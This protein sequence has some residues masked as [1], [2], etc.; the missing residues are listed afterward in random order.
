MQK[1]VVKILEK[2]HSNKLMSEAAEK[3]TLTQENEELDGEG[4]ERW[5]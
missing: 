2:H 3:G 4:G 5:W 1:R